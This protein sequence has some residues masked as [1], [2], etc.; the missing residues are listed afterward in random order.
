[1]AAEAYHSGAVRSM[2]L[3]MQDKD[4]GF[5]TVNGSLRTVANVANGI[6]ALRATLGGGSDGQIRAPFYLTL[7]NVAEPNLKKPGLAVQVAPL[8]YTNGLAYS[9]SPPQVK[10]IVTAGGAM[11]M[12]LFFPNGLNMQAGA[13]F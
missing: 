7:A 9:R 8:N 5:G 2:L 10:S 1:M 13:P 6:A 11:S 4:A 12:G 3:A